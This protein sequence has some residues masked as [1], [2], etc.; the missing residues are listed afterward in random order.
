MI[1]EYEDYRVTLNCR[2]TQRR[3]LSHTTART[4]TLYCRAHCLVPASLLH[5]PS[6]LAMYYFQS[7][8]ST[9]QSQECRRGQCPR[10]RLERTLKFWLCSFMAKGEQ[11]EFYQHQGWSCSPRRGTYTVRCL[12][13]AWGAVN[14]EECSLWKSILKHLL[15][16][17]LFHFAKTMLFI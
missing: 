4:K 10:G 9:A 7:A 17:A 12:C 13:K 2:S 5:Q 14:G 1:Q 6:P 11:E 16:N 8:K 15:R 3:F